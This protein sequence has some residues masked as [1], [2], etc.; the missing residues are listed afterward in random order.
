MGAIKTVTRPQVAAQGHQE[1]TPTDWMGM[2]MEWQSCNFVCE[3]IGYNMYRPKY[4][5]SPTECGQFEGGWGLKKIINRWKRIRWD[6]ITKRREKRGNRKGTSSSDIA[7]STVRWYS[8]DE[9][10][11]IGCKGKRQVIRETNSWL[12]RKIVFMIQWGVRK[13]RH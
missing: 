1:G 10:E 3:S 5:H 9:C 6:L 7:T 13:I 12:R 4:A 2:T 11:S 8:S